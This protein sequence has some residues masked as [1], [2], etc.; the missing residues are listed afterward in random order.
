M[1]CFCAP[2]RTWYFQAPDQLSAA[3]TLYEIV[4]FDGVLYMM[5]NNAVDFNVDSLAS[6]DSS[7][8]VPSGIINSVVVG[9]NKRVVEIDV[10]IASVGTYMISVTPITTNGNE[11]PRRAVLVVQSL[12]GT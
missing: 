8:S 6:I 1:N 11:V 5:F 4:G 12:T 10:T 9:D 7:Q 3:N 2:P